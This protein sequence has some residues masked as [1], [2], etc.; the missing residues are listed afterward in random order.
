MIWLF[1]PVTV[2]DLFG[3]MDGADLQKRGVINTQNTCRFVSFF[4]TVLPLDQPPQL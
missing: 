3:Q 2:E 4:T 1:K